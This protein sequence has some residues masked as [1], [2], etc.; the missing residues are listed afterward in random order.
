MPLIAFG[1]ESN[2]T[3]R[4]R[5]TGRQINRQTTESGRWATMHP[6]RQPEAG[7][8]SGRGTG[9]RNRYRFDVTQKDTH[10]YIQRDK[11]TERNTD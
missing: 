2:Q 6:D 10:T 1:I 8:H 5:K 11:D 4:R 7:G 9:A 3:E